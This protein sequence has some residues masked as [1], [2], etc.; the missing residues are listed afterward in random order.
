M[1]LKISF[2]KNAILK[3]FLDHAEKLV[4]GL[5]IFIVATIL[6]GAVMRREKYDKIPPDLHEKSSNAQRE[7][8]RPFTADAPEFKNLPAHDYIRIAKKIADFSSNKSITEGPYQCDIP[9]KSPLFEQKGL[10]GSPKYLGVR[11]LRATADLGAFTETRPR[12]GA[13]LPARSPAGGAMAPRAAVGGGEITGKCWVVITG[14]V[15]Y[16]EQLEAYKNAFRDTVFYDSANDVPVYMGYWV[17]RAEISS[18]NE[19][20]KWR[21]TFFSSNAIPEAL[22]N[23]G[24]NMPDVIEVKY[25]DPSLTFPLGPLVNDTWGA[26][27]AHEPEIPLLSPEAALGGAEGGRSAFAGNEENR[28][29]GTSS[30]E[31]VSQQ[32]RPVGTPNR[33]PLRPNPPGRIVNDSGETP[34]HAV[35]FARY[36]LFRFFDFSVEPGKSYLYRVRLALKNPNNGLKSGLVQDTNEAQKKMLETE[37]VILSKIVYVPKDTQILLDSV[38][39]RTAGVPSGK[40]LLLKWLRESG[41]EVFKEFSPID[42]GQVLNF[43]D[44][45]AKP[46]PVDPSSGGAPA[47]DIENVNFL[48]DA[49]VLDISGGRKLTIGKDKS[50]TEPGEMLLMLMNNNSPMLMVHNELE[51]TAEIKRLT[52]EPESPSGFERKSPPN[53][54][55]APGGEGARLL[56]EPGPET[57]PKRPRPR[58]P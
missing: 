12:P 1:K 33:A 40:V 58:G 54:R 5:F 36:K 30:F 51:D 57:P 8:E 41:R 50:L 4:L 43:L 46:A 2:N 24:Q 26:E 7:L 20:P 18:P 6:Y 48:A 47:G 37:G 15:P 35:Q 10:R 13:A 19:K 56:L 14:L 31:G 44:E 11:D 52:T 21:K 53:T 45:K 55:A 9:W 22:N 17:D 3:F 27:V 34:Y 42:R 39:P 23:W 32:Q 16:E 38:N 29:A 28:P 25:R 49:T